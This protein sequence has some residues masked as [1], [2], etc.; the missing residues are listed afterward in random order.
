MSGDS[1]YCHAAYTRDLKMIE[2][3]IVSGKGDLSSLCR[4]FVRK[5]DLINRWLSGDTS[6][7][8]AISVI[9]A[10]G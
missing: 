3:V 7:P 9:A 10:F 2:D 6:R 8:S 5:P 4:P 1:K